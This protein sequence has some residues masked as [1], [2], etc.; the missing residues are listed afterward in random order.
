MELT[1]IDS[2]AG[3]PTFFAS[4]SLAMLS[5]TDLMFF[6]ALTAPGRANGALMRLFRDG[7]SFDMMPICVGKMEWTVNDLR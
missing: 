2:H 5:Y 6:G 7:E 4:A 3:T 1:A